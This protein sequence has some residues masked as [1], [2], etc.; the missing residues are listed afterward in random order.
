MEDALVGRV[1]AST[2][3]LKRVVEVEAGLFDWR[4]YLWVQQSSR[5]EIERMKSAKGK[6]ALSKR[7]SRVDDDQDKIR[8]SGEA[9]EERLYSE[10]IAFACDFVGDTLTGVSILPTLSN[11]ARYEAAIERTLYH[12]LHELQ[13]LQAARTGERVP[14]P[15][16]V[17]INISD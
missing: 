5:R 11:L 3:R 13:R 6:V 4:H 12:A 16:A 7:I 9:A 17:D 1:I 14:L 15:L 10:P 8:G 2:W